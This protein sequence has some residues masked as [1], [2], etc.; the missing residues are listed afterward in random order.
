[1][2]FVLCKLIVYF[3]YLFGV[4]VLIT[5][6]TPPSH[7]NQH[8]YSSEKFNAT[9]STFHIYLILKT[10]FEFVISLNL[11]QAVNIFVLLRR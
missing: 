8:M 1:M 3:I 11:G 7:C 4:P 6:M 5:K 9:T 2:P 10:R